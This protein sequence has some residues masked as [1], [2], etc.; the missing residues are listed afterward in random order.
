M[1]F[2]KKSLSAKIT[3]KLLIIVSIITII[4]AI[5]AYLATKQYLYNSYKKKVRDLV[6]ITADQIKTVFEH[7]IDSERHSLD[8]FVNPNHREL[9]IE[10]CVEIWV[11][12]E[13]KENG[14]FDRKYLEKIFLNE[15]KLKS[16]AVDRYKRL[17]TDYSVDK[18]LDRKIKKVTDG[19]RTVNEIGFSTFM[20]PK[21][22]VPFH[23]SLNSKKLTGDPKKDTTGC[24][25]N[26]VWDYLGSK[27]K[28]DKVVEHVYPRD[29]GKVL[30]IA[31]APV[32]LKEKFVGAAV[33]GYTIE[34]INRE[35]FIATSIVVAVIL[36]G[37]LIIFIGFN[38]LIKKNLRSIT[39]ISDILKKVGEDGDFTQNID[40]SSEDEIGDISKNVNTM[41]DQSSRTI[42]YLKIA[43]TSLAASS[44]ELTA[45]SVGLGQSSTG[46][47]ES[48]RGIKTELNLVLQSIKET[49]DFIGD[50]VADIST[51]AESITSLEDM[52]KK[53]SSN[54]KLVLD[55]SNDSITISKDGEALVISA[56]D[57]MKLIVDSSKR[58]GDMVNIINDISDQINLLSLNASIEAARAGEAGRGFAVVA[59]EI[60]KLAENTSNQVSE[61][62][63]LSS[64]I[65]KSVTEGS[66][67]VQ[68]IR[69]SISTIMSNIIENSTLIEEISLLSDNQT[70][71]HNRMR[72][73]MLELEEKSKKIIDVADFQ[74]SNSESIENA[75]NEV[76]RL[77]TETSAGS[78]EIA[79]SSEELAQRA[80]E[81]NQL[82]QGF[83]TMEPDD[84]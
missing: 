62:H 39:M 27:M 35:I 40:Y 81:L 67:M 52:S 21:G 59:E 5:G 31:F 77:T 70:D 18:E 25:T 45:T 38:I 68:K 46:Q 58:I 56:W 50:Q 78:E 23:H 61:I 10:E 19:F 24:R 74:R 17:A 75:M 66:D 64:E 32:K 22:F 55:K 83:K 14:K 4:M 6:T 29:T 69:E 42:Y 84:E 11:K 57:A 13:D 76:L 30:I 54:M 9:S 36:L 7:E 1:Q 3:L 16:G 48:I 73:V 47:V 60:G 33:T 51:T 71:N 72:N 43:A 79:A 8:E 80:E 26:R 2:I 28:P 63:S 20:D 44:E 82:V 41:I 34:A 37:S 53:I 65:E 12:P 49:T 15:V